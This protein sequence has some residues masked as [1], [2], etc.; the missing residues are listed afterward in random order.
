M[1]KGESGT[2][3][4]AEI[5]TILDNAQTIVKPLLAKIEEFSQV[6]EMNEMFRFEF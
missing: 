6:Q 1:Q 3:T 4:Q 2:F 5:E